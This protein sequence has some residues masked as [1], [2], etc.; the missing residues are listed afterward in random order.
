VMDVRPI[1]SS[2]YKFSSTYAATLDHL[3]PP[4]AAALY[5][6]ARRSLCGTSLQALLPCCAVACASAAGIL[7]VRA[8]S[9]PTRTSPWS[10][11]LSSLPRCLGSPRALPSAGIE[12][13]GR[14]R[15]L[16]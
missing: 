3:L 10:S 15:L 1:A 13:L 11:M 12:P 7:N 5:P 4:A 14:P 6:L 2:L 9:S 8:C 16:P